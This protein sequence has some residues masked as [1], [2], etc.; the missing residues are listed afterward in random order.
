MLHSQ[1]GSNTGCD[2]RIHASSFM[3]VY[4]IFSCILGDTDQPRSLAELATVVLCGSV[5]FLP[6]FFQLFRGHKN[7]SSN[8][9]PSSSKER[10]R[11][12]GS[13]SRIPNDAAPWTEI[14][15]PTWKTGARYI[16]LQEVSIKHDSA[17]KANTRDYESVA[18]SIR[19]TI[20]IET[21][22]C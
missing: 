22:Q 2:I 1:M 18:G 21:H 12:N 6:K 16:P 20:D 3:G 7:T 14:D 9:Q 17:P 4:I 10:S 13:R 5:I 19:K 11:Q 8:Q 15:H